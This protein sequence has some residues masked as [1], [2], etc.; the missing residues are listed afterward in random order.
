MPKGSAPWLIAVLLGTTLLAGCGPHQREVV[1]YAALDREF[2]EPVFNAYSQQSGVKVLAKYDIESTKTTGLV[3]TIITEQG[4]PRCDVFWNNEILHTI[5]LQHLGLLTAYES[6]H[7][8][9]FAA[10]HRSATGRWYGLAARARVL[11]V[12]TR[13]LPAGKRPTSIQALIRPEYKGKCGIAKPLYGTTATHA[14]VLFSQW[15]EARATRFFEQVHASAVVMQGNKAVAQAVASGELHFGLTDT[16]DAIIEVER[17]APV[18]IVFPDQQEDGAGA[19]RIPTTLCILKGSPHQREAELLVDYLLQP[20][21]EQRLNEGPSAQMPLH[22]KST[23]V[24]R[25]LPAE[26]IRWMRADFEQAATAWDTAY[27]VLREIFE[28]AQ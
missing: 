9:Q 16:D 27:P 15:G 11:L 19:L 10:H 23:T 22:L 12:N 26:K 6:P 24:A 7:A 20:G 2:S 28:T 3:N 4:R 17:G 8:A 21:V 1:V 5:R 18:A 25:I 13:K 14:A